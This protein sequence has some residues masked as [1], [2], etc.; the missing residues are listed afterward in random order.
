[1]PGVRIRLANEAPVRP[2]RAYVVYWMVA[3]RRARSNFAPAA[4]G[5]AGRRAEPAAGRLRAAARRLSLGE[6]SPARVRPAG[7]GRQRPGVRPDAGPLFS[8]RRGRARRR[9]GAARGAGGGCR[10]RRHRRRPVLLPAADDCR[11]GR[12]PR[13]AGRGRRRQRPAPAAR[14]RPRLPDGVLVSRPPAEGRCGGTS[15]TCRSPTRWPAS[16]CRRRPALDA[17]TGA[18]ARGAARR[19]CPATPAALARLPID[20]DVAP[21]VDAGRR[22]GRPRPPGGVRRRRPRHLRRRSPRSRRADAPAACRRTCISATC[23]RTRSSTR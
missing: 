14:R 7:H 6:R 20:H 2:D 18:V 21:V 23:R 13:R 10:R 11:S 16:A 19:C 17:V 8:L 22:R 1:M 9:P 3:A 5:R 15:T 12:P 4:G